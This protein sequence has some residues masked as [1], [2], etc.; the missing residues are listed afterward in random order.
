MQTPALQIPAFLHQACGLWQTLAGRIGM[1]D[2]ILWLY[3]KETP[4]EYYSGY[5]DIGLGAFLVEWLF[6][7]EN[8][9]NDQERLECLLK[10]IGTLSKRI[11][12]NGTRIAW[13][14]RL[15]SLTR[16]Y[17]QEHVLSWEHILNHEYVVKP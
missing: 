3:G 9:R 12:Q 1:V 15:K 14:E 5:L 11:E 10:N 7:P 13:K 6:F 4:G 2:W 17:Y 16:S 8:K